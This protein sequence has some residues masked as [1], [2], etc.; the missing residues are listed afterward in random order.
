MLL[1]VAMSLGP[2]VVASNDGEGA[3]GGPPALVPTEEGMPHLVVA[4]VGPIVGVCGGDCDT[5]GVSFK[6]SSGLSLIQASQRRIM[7]FNLTPGKW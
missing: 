7:S 2:G 1:L 4:L 5:L 3:R 6:L